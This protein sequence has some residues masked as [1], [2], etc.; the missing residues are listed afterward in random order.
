MAATPVFRIMQSQH[1]AVTQILGVR[2]CLQ[3]SARAII[4]HTVPANLAGA[5][6]E[7]HWLTHSRN[8]K[9]DAFEKAIESEYVYVHSAVVAVV[10]VHSGCRLRLTEH[11]S[12][13]PGVVGV[14]IA[15]AHGLSLGGT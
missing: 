3:R 11:R 6:Q 8:K 5:G 2:V 1:Q 7:L 9:M 12:A 4:L 14:L 10:A 15:D 13:K